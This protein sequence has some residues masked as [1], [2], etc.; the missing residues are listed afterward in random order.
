MNALITITEQNGNQVVNARELHQF[1]EVDTKFTMWL[2]RRINEYGFTENE[3]FEVLPNFGKNSKGGRPSKEYAISL[4]MAKELSMVE[5]NEKGKQARRYFI[6]CEKQMKK[7]SI[8][9]LSSA[10]NI[11]QLPLQPI[12]EKRKAMQKELMQVIRLNLN[13]G[14]LKKLS[15]NESIPYNRIINVISSKTFDYN[16]IVYL[17]EKARSNMMFLDTEIATMTEDLKTLSA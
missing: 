12:A 3:D 8:N 5:R 2:E 4:D 6:E 14:D 7:E 9:S 15:E 13:R 17:Y 1:L 11:L 10:S 16:V